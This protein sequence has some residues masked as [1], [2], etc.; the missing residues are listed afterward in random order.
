MTA[1][2]KTKP[3]AKKRK[4]RSP[5]DP[6]EF[7]LKTAGEFTDQHVKVIAQLLVDLED[8]PARTTGK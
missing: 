8:K 4:P 3:K 7:P 1:K 2:P 6:D 5:P